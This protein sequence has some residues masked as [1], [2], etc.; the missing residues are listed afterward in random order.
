MHLKKPDRIELLAGVWLFE[1]CTRKELDALQ[2]V[3]TAV[4]APAGK[5]LATAGRN[6]P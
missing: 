5:V 2:R 6:R 1:R 3:A 4:D